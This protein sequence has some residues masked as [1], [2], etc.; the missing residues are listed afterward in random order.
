[1]RKLRSSLF[2]RFVLATSLVV[3]LIAILL[4]FELRANVSQTTAIVV[5]LL[6]LLVLLGVI[7]V[8]TQRTLARDLRELSLALERVLLEGGLDRM[9]Q[10]RLAELNG[11][12]QEMDAVAARVRNDYLQLTSERD[13]LQAVLDNI[14]AGVIVVDRK[15]KIDMINP[16]ALKIL[17]TTREFALGRTFTEI[18][19]SPVI[20][21]A[22]EKSRRGA[23]VNKE[24][25]I[26]LPD[27]RWLRVLAS[28][29]R[30]EKGRTTGVI[31]VIEDITSRRKLERVR[32]DFVTNVSHELRTPVA[33]M[34]AVVEALLAG[35]SDEPE[36]CARFMT[37]LDRE[38]GRLVDII[39]DLLVLSR[40]E[41]A[42]GTVE[43]E[44]LRLEE[45]L[46]EAVREKEELAGKYQVEL[47]FADTGREISVRGDRGLIKTA[48]AN[49]LDN[50]IKYNRP[51]GR[52]EVSLERADE[53]VTVSVSDDGVGIPAS[54]RG[55]IFERF[56]RV[57]KA[58]S[59]NTGGTGLGLSIVKHAAEYHGGSVRVTST[60]GRGSTF[61]ITL[62]A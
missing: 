12:A 1:M 32:R 19:H 58:R 16:V 43:V 48:F 18:H 3:L 52:V 24:I 6:A 35:A 57:D 22:I 17:G 30:S 14:S 55:R 9:P 2:A 5:A 27:R 21:R 33:N 41:A 45:I 40:L 4:V 60:E 15:L 59:R 8:W 50:A 29:I 34:R 44:T 38:S 51:G 62:P 28:P 11:I 20:D 61:S 53:F 39:E 37:D 42:G 25:Q 56:Y 54:D 7:T 46:K 23:V 49:L 26:T 10:P 36:A 31:C 47:I 13:R